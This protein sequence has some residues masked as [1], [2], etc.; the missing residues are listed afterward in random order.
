M[1]KI[2]K[3]EVSAFKG[4][5]SPIELDLQNCPNLLIYGENGSGKSSLY[6]AL[7]YALRGDTNFLNENGLE[8]NNIRNI[9]ASADDKTYVKLYFD[10]REIYEFSED[11]VVSEELQKEIKNGFYA[12]EIINYKSLYSFHNFRND[13]KIDLFDV[14]RHEFFPFWE[15]NTYGMFDNWYRNFGERLRTLRGLGIDTKQNPLKY[16]K[17][18]EEL[19]VFSKA[20]GQKTMLLVPLLNEWYQKLTKE[21][22]ISISLS[23]GYTKLP[24]KANQLEN[25]TISM[26]LELG[27]KK[28]SNPH[29]YLNEARLNMVALAIHLAHIDLRLATS[30]IK[31]LILDDLLLSLDMSNRD[32]IL[33]L[34][35]KEFVD[36]YQVFIF[37]HDE[38]FYNL[39]KHKTLS[40]DWIGYKIYEDKINKKPHIKLDEDDFH[41][42]KRFF[43]D[44][45]FDACANHLR[46]EAERLLKVYLD[47]DLSFI[48]KDFKSL[49]DLIKTA[50]NKVNEEDLAS[51][52]RKFKLQ[53]SETEIQDF[54]QL[55]KKFENNEIFIELPQGKIRGVLKNLMLFFLDMQKNKSNAKEIINDL[56]NIKNRILNPR[57]HNQ[58]TN[59]TPLYQKELEK[60]IE[61]IEKLRKFLEQVNNT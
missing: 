4:F 44:R 36:K 50:H 12:S 20:L 2:I 52:E 6:W 48:E 11:A 17:L 3:I 38:G 46:K 24:Q 35:F 60:A 22:E 21:T 13:E 25:S 7:Y 5:S 18:R 33:N 58:I 56:E 28:I 16:K 19:E 26:D 10:T 54:E 34:I 8:N 61:N 9:Y 37:T 31:L 43:E 45:E 32:K 49:Q 55:T 47:K 15:D 40:R 59:I 23:C 27:G 51:F 14:F 42:A 39:I 29:N 57:S 1:K 30:E 41:K 53:L